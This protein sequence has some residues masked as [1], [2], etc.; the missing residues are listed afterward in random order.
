MRPPHPVATLQV[1]TVQALSVLALTGLG[2]VNALYSVSYWAG[3]PFVYE[4]A[5]HPDDHRVR[6]ISYASS[7]GADPDKQ[8]LD[9]FVPEEKAPWPVLV[10]V[11][12]GG[13]TEGDRSLR[14]GGRDVYANI[15]RYFA[16]RGVGT[17]VIS[18][19]LQPQVTWREQLDDVSQAVAWVH[20]HVAGYG[21]DP[22]RIFVSGHSAGAQLVTWVALDETRLARLGAGNPRLC[23]LIPVSGA[24]LDLTDEQTWA[25]GASPAYFEQR[26]GDGESGEAW[27]REAS[28]IFHVRQDSPPTLVIYASGE[29]EDIKRQS[30]LLDRALRAAGAESRTVLVPDEDHYRIILALSRPDKTAAP[31]I[32]E[33]IRSHD[34]PP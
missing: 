23:G 7:P 13:W 27:Q 14:A 28:P 24:A 26:F 22:Q 30:V 18:Y 19:R 1:L 10:F 6:D 15:G 21:G 31:A 25:L 34:C 20:D 17:A 5:D 8:R 29:P 16:S 2:C 4:H 3:M 12:G 33:F 32:L 9:L 11:H